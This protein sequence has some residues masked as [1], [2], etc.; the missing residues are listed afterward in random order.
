MKNFFIITNGLKDE[1]LKVTKRLKSYIEY[2]GANVS[3][4]VTM[5]EREKIYSV[6]EDTIP[7]GTQLIFV[8]GGD[9]TLLRVSRDLL[10]L[11]I[12]FIGVNLGTLGYLCELVED[13]MCEAVDRI[14]N[15][16]YMVEDR[17]MLKSLG[18]DKGIALNDIV[19]HREGKTQM[20]RLTIYLNG[21]FLGVYNADGIIV[22]TPTGSTGYNMSAGG[23]IVDPQAQMILITPINSHTLG[24]KSIVISDSDKVEIELSR[25]RPQEDETASICYDG[26]VY[27]TIGV[28][29]R[30]EIVRTRRTV[31]IL[32]LNDVSFWGILQ[33]KMRS[34][35]ES[36]GM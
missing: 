33:A 8:L 30:I 1:G 34:E 25:R 22:A 10:R 13:T 28:G 6:S 12:P 20:V 15:N 9:G 24:N 11:Q 2:R 29:E 31:K 16:E 4:H 36:R 32:K 26:D 19:I 35:D 27:R 5:M 17:M 23:P 21:L 7:E 3:Y 18:E 14:M